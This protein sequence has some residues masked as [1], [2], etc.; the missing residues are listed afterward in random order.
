MNPLDLQEVISLAS[1]DLAAALA[2]LRTLSPQ[3]P[4]EAHVAAT[5]GGL[6][7]DIGATLRD[8]GILRDGIAAIEGCLGGL[9]PRARPYAFYNLGKC[10]AALHLL[11]VT[12]RGWNGAPIGA[13]FRG[14]GSGAD[15]M[16]L[17]ESCYGV[18]TRACRK[19]FVD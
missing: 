15:A 18:L 19:A 7:V 5:Y 17:P 8:I 16:A 13:S 9:R 1:R 2:H 10:Y 3:P 14:S 4:L 11:S 6:L 12:S